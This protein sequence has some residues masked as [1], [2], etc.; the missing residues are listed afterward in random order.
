MGLG[1]YLA[2]ITERDHFRSEQAREKSIIQKLSLLETEERVHAALEKYG[3]ERNDV[4]PISRSLRKDPAK[5]LQVPW[6]FSIIAKLLF[7]EIS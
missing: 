7:S 6:I 4:L 2:A 5:Y 1:A 3:V